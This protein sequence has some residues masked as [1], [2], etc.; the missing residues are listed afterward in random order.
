MKFNPSKKYRTFLTPLMT[1]GSGKK[2]ALKTLPQV[3]C[4]Y[5]FVRDIAIH[6]L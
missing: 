5:V 1:V 6:P 4:T 3:I 2:M